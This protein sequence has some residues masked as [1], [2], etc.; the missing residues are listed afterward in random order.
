[1]FI[2]KIALAFFCAQGAL[3]QTGKSGRVSKPVTPALPKVEERT[4]VVTMN[5][6]WVTSLI[7]VDG[8]QLKLNL[9]K[10]R[11]LQARDTGSLKGLCPEGQEFKDAAIDFSAS[12]AA[13]ADA[14][15]SAFSA[16]IGTRWQV[17]TLPEYGRDYNPQYIKLDR[18][19]SELR[20]MKH[21]GETN[22]EKTKEILARQAELVREA[23]NSGAAHLRVL[24]QKMQTAEPPKKGAAIKLPF[25]I[26]YSCQVKEG[27]A[28]P[29]EN[30]TAETPD[31][32]Q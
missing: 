28:G 15:L 32:V 31:A 14:H 30:Q 2:L 29:T 3:A 22:D 24:I 10:L 18:T 26:R 23:H 4:G 13:V 17:V 11:A 25:P 1:M 7:E 12:T 5:R 8:E 21:N 20:Q 19:I 16:V 9:K 6:N 27:A